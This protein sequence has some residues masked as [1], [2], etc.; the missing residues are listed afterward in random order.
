MTLAQGYSVYSRVMM[1]YSLECIAGWIRGMRGRV[2][3]ALHDMAELVMHDDTA[4]LPLLNDY[5]MGTL[6]AVMVGLNMKADLP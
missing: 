1:L 3:K 5:F 2:E 4:E 6:S